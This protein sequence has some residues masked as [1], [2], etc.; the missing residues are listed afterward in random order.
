M[1]RRAEGLTN[2]LDK[3]SMSLTVSPS[4][5]LLKLTDAYALTG[6]KILYSFALGFLALV[7]Q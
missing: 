3:H 6:L 7:W 1:V 4:N 2:V 5:F